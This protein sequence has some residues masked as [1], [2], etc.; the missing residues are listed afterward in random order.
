MQIDFHH[1]TMYVVPRKAGFSH[2]DADIFAYASQYVDDATTTGTVYFDRRAVYN[3]I[4]SA[5][6]MLD[7]RSRRDAFPLS[8]RDFPA[9]RTPDLQRNEK[10]TR[11]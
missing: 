3:P 1:A 8:A 6:K 10:A 11:G 9:D 2:D 5:H 7:C 4:S